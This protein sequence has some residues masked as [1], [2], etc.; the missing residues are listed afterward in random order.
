MWYGRGGR[1]FLDRRDPTPRS[2]STWSPRSSLFV[3]NEEDETVWSEDTEEVER[4]ERSAERWKF[5][6]DDAP[7]IGPDGAEEH[8]RELV[9][10]A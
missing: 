2:S 4:Q 3:F 6:I 9:D 7:P 10:T 5:D 8:D 1:V